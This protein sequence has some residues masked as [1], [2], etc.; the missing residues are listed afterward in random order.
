[1]IKE[2]VLCLDEKIVRRPRDVDAGMIFGTGFPPFRGGLLKYADS[3]GPNVCV[4][5]MEELRKLF[6]EHFEP[7]KLLR[8]M[9]EAGETFYPTKSVS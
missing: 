2:A 1:M 4:Q 8:K 5:K 3:M 6:G 7:P 9:A